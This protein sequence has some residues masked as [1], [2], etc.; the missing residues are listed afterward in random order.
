MTLRMGEGGWMKS[1]PDAH[2]SYVGWQNDRPERETKPL[3][4]FIK[5]WEVLSGG[6]DFFFLLELRVAKYSE[7]ESSID[8]VYDV[9]NVLNITGGTANWRT[10]K[11]PCEY[12]D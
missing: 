6:P 2:N 1:S 4:R 3:I 9:R 12:P 5:A 10:C 11:I 8:Y 7:G